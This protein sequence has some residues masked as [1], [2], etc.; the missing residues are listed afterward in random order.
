MPDVF[1]KGFISYGDLNMLID[2]KYRNADP[3]FRVETDMNSMGLR[4]HER[5]GQS[6]GY[7]LIQ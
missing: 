3:V 7:I 5:Q 2:T 6:F 1:V 4:I